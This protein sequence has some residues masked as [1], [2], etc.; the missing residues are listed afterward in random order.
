M[1]SSR[2]VPWALLGLLLLAPLARG[3]PIPLVEYGFTNGAE[4]WMVEYVDSGTWSMADFRHEPEWCP[5][6]GN[7]GG[8]IRVWD[9]REWTAYFS[10]PPELL[11]FGDNLMHSVLTVD[12]LHFG[13][14]PTID[15]DGDILLVSPGM[16]LGLDLPIPG[17]EWSFDMVRFNDEEAWHTIDGHS[18]TNNELLAVLGSLEY[19]LI[20]GDHREGHN[21]VGS[22]DNVI[23][24]GHGSVSGLGRDALVSGRIHP[25]VT[26][27]PFTWSIRVAQR[28]PLRIDLYRPDGRWVQTLLSSMLPAGLHEIDLDVR[29]A[30]LPA[31]MYYLNLQTPRASAQR[32]LVLLK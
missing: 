16:T 21:D 19:F 7:P 17:T 6:D 14:G 24:A 26:A 2:C 4:E 18:P 22:L 12:R 10:A 15:R 13:S 28:G 8:H 11:D 3:N 25:S 32:R 29:R 20:L 9:S 27:G 5:S 1:T 30:D 23:G 31:G